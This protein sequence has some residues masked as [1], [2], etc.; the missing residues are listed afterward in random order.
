MVESGPS[1]FGVD[2]DNTFTDTDGHM[3]ATLT[4]QIP[5]YVHYSFESLTPDEDLPDEFIQQRERYMRHSPYILQLSL[6]PGAREGIIGLGESKYVNGRP[7]LNTARK[8]NQRDAIYELLDIRGLR[9][10]DV[11][12]RGITE[13]KS[14]GKLRNVRQH[15][16]RYMIEDSGIPAILFAEELDGVFLIDQPWNRWVPRDPRII[17]CCSIEDV[18]NFLA[19]KPPREIFE[20]HAF[21]VQRDIEKFRSL[22]S[23]YP[24]SALLS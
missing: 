4:A 3:K 1:K 24:V 16:I 13:D 15:G 7:Y 5:G 23:R 6:L 18:A 14:V 11:L 17:R 2:L 22:L 19:T 10:P 21:R 20:R 12:L 9:F 8:V